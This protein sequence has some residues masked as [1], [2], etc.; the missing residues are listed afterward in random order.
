MSI[1]QLIKKTFALGLQAPD[2][3]SSIVQGRLEPSRVL[4]RAPGLGS[5]GGQVADDGVP[6]W[7]R[8]GNVGAS[9]TR[10][11]QLFLAAKPMEFIGP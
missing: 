9:P 5:V 3:L 8:R 4:R 1:L 10:P 7:H 11:R 6:G 2:L